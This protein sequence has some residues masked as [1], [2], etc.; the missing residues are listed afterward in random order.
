MCKICLLLLRK[1]KP[2]TI[3]FSSYHHVVNYF[4]NQWP[5]LF[6]TIH[7]KLIISEVIFR[8][9]WWTNVLGKIYQLIL[10]ISIYKLLK[11]FPQNE[12]FRIFLH[13]FRKNVWN[14]T[15]SSLINKWE[16][17]SLSS[18]LYKTINFNCYFM[19]F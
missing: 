17:Y 16:M 10:I 13:I 8:I 9:L 1:V 11:K 2:F 7:W 14:P 15:E 18:Q 5:S 4:E 19:L 3:Y 6:K 12:I